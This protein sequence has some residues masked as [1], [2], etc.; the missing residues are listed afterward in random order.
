MQGRQ[1][2]VK[3]IL[4]SQPKPENGKSPY[5]NLAQKHK[6]KIDFVPFIH[7]EEITTQEFKKQK[8]SILNHDAVIFTS[9]NAMDHYFMMCEKLRIKVPET[10][11]YFCVSEAIAYYLQNFITFRKRKVFTGE[12]MFAQL[13]PIL[14]KHK[15]CKFL[16]PCSDLIKERIVDTLTS[17]E[18]NF[19]KSVMYKVACS[20]L[21][22]L[23]D[24]YY[25]VLVF[26]SPTGITSLYE[27]FPNFRQKDTRIAAFGPTTAKSV[28]DHE[29]ILDI[30]APNEKAPSMSMA[31]DQYIKVSN[32]R[33]R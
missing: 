22:D 19:T 4:I 2:K 16:L 7:V 3:S 5:F 17:N 23:E 13:I 31:L 11:K 24:V 20:D 30:N 12:Q 8:I 21:S 9:K 28:A 26:F 29:L 10:M 27:N 1:K 18:I 33:K 15:E 6:L 25:D 14:K 32:K